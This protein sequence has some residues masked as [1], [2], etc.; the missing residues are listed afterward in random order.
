[1]YLPNW[2]LH[3]C[4]TQ[5]VPC[6]LLELKTS[7]LQIFFTLIHRKKQILHP[8]SVNIYVYICM[9]LCIYVYINLN[10]YNTDT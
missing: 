7:G 5:N 4:N 10:T 6:I 3:I 9:A 2:I 8:N 1:M